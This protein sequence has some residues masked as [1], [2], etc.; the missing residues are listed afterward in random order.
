VAAEVFTIYVVRYDVS[1]CM[2]YVCIL[3]VMIYA[4]D[5]TAYSTCMYCIHMY[6]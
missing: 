5:R 2:Y 6:V 1:I 3:V 4:R